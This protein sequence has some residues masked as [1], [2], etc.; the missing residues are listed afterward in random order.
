M[1]IEVAAA[2][3]MPQRTLLLRRFVIL[4]EINSIASRYSYITKTPSLKKEREKRKKKRTKKEPKKE[5]K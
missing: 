2:R 1:P 3:V 4:Y 5:K